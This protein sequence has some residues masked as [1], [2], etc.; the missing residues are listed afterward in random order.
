MEQWTQSLV[1]VRPL[2]DGDHEAWKRAFS[3]RRPAT[4]A[5]D[6]GP[7]PLDELSAERYSGMLARHARW[8][9][10][11]STRVL[12]VFAATTGELVGWVDLTT[13]A[14]DEREWANL[15]FHIHNQFRLRGYG[16]AAIRAA[17]HHGFTALRYHRIE[18]A[19]RLDNASAIRTVESAG[20]EREG[21]RRRFWRDPDGWTDHV[22]YAAIAE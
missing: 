22:I 2:D 17:V 5:H 7:I 9:S 21:I 3:E 6:E 13:L 20:L 19:I 14:R 16:R 10:A 1:H 11:D 18:A 12:G 4:S 15:G 8:A